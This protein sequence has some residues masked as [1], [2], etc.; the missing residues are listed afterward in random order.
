MFAA[1]P[2]MFTASVVFRN[3]VARWKRQ[4]NL[5]VTILS[6]SSSSSL[7]RILK[8]C[9]ALFEY[10]PSAL[11]YWDM[12]GQF[13]TSFHSLLRI[14]GSFMFS[15]V[16]YRRELVSLSDG[17]IVAID[18]ATCCCDEPSAPIVIIQHGLCGSSSSE[19]IVHAVSA[20]T[21]KGFRVGVM[22]AR[23][24]GGLSLPTP[25][26]FSASRTSD[27]RAI[28]EHVRRLYPAPEQKVFGLGFSLGAA[29]LLSYLGIHSDKSKLDGAMAV[30]PPWDFHETT[31]VFAMWSGIFALAIKKYLLT[32]RSVFGMDLCYRV[33]A[34][35]SIRAI[36]AAVAHLHGHSHV[37]EYY[38]CSS[39]VRVSAGICTPT[40]VVSSTD[41]PV[42]GF[43]ALHKAR[44]AHVQG[45]LLPKLV[46]R[47]YGDVMGPEMIVAVVEIGGHLSFAEGWLPLAANWTDRV[48]V[49]WFENLLRNSID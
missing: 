28:V 29:V 3:C 24:C 46:H 15:K 38:D 45:S 6:N 16:Q 34:A 42:C 14:F 11:F 41:D 33:L 36:D 47:V 4:F 8:E 13:Q 27:F 12:H 7:T 31:T 32:H 10:K 19:Y 30:S 17:G 2:L 43:P 26:P 9:S 20:L 40:L 37:D 1:A 22:I 18:W 5:P 39:P 35:P 23:G 44:M 49:Q 25:V 48:V 21:T